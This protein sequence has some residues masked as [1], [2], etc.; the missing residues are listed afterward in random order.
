MNKG[1]QKILIVKYPQNYPRPGSV[2][3]KTHAE[4]R[5]GE[6]IVAQKAAVGLSAGT[7]G[8]LAGRDSSAVVSHD[9]QKTSSQPWPASASPRTCPATRRRSRPSRPAS[10]RLSSETGHERSDAWQAEQQRI[11]DEANRKRAE[12][13]NERRG[14]GGMLESKPVVA[15]PVQV[16]E[17][18]ETP[19]KTRQAKATASKTNRGAVE[20]GDKLANERPDLAE[21]VKNGDIAPSEALRQSH[22]VRRPVPSACRAADRGSV[23]GA[24]NAGAESSRH[25]FQ[26]WNV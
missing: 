10:S 19:D 15:Q 9:R 5:L 11:Q 4:R 22:R 18:R 23:G 8:Q 14:D 7:R 20:R 13:A 6:M 24:G 25:T 16:Q 1:F 3:K 12:A 26:R 21:K 17:R 2:V